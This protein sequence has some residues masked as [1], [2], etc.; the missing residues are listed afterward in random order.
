MLD[1]VAYRS[2]K[3]PTAV[4]DFII[5]RNASF[6]STLDSLGVM[7]RDEVYERLHSEGRKITD[8]AHGLNHAVRSRLLMEGN[9]LDHAW[10]I[11]RHSIKHQTSKHHQ[12]ID[13]MET[14]LKAIDPDQVLS[15]G[16]T[17][18]SVEGQTITHADALVSGMTI[19]TCLLYTSRCV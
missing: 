10:N 19:Q 7:I 2:L 5:E 11:M 17:I 18:T 15:R 1:L 8:L 6:E 12:R 3:T 14:L 16:Y 9:K 4:A 13:F